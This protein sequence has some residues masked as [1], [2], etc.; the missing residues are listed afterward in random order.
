MRICSGQKPEVA[1]GIS[2]PAE[3]RAQYDL[4]GGQLVDQQQPQNGE[5]DGE[6]RM[7]HTIFHAL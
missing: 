3:Q 1:K 4:S 7:G 5:R 6:Q 2:Q